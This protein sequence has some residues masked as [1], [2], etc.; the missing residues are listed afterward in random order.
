MGEID[1]NIGEQSIGLAG[2]AT[3]MPTN[4][5]SD[6]LRQLLPN[7]GFFISRNVFQKIFLSV[8]KSLK[9]P[10]RPVSKKVNP[11]VSLNYLELI[12]FRA[13]LNAPEGGYQSMHGEGKI[14]R[15]SK[16]S[17]YYGDGSITTLSTSALAS[18]L[19]SNSVIAPVEN[20]EIFSSGPR[21][22]PSESRSTHFRALSTS[23]E[24]D[25]DSSVPQ[26]RHDR[27]CK[28]SSRT[29]WTPEMNDLFVRAYNS[30]IGEVPTPVRILRF[31][32]PFYPDL[33]QK[34]VQS[35]LQKY[36]LQN[37]LRA[38][39][40]HQSIPHSR[41]QASQQPPQQRSRE[42][43]SITPPSTC[44][45]DSSLLFSELESIPPQSLD[46]PV[47]DPICATDATSAPD[48]KP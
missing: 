24:Y 23:P 3:A 28:A 30:I 43:H 26:K 22:R 33:T 46:P 17:Q 2:Y 47:V 16:C 37:K 19:E 31:M 34:H 42:L 15:A 6:E 32:S 9:P 11:S 13:D 48:A 29:I 12:P 40:S 4:L 38:S 41:H 35:K 25:P 8:C 39:V 14:E 10:S 45:V 7:D 20:S 21:E 5:Y 1:A 44:L 27:V 18:K 36:R